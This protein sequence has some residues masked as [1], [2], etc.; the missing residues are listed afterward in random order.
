MP[1]LSLALVVLVAAPT[2]THAGPLTPPAGAPTPTNKTLSE[3]EPRIPLTQDT[4]PGTGF[5]VFNIL[6][7]GSYY[8][9][10]DLQAANLSGFGIVIGVSDVTIDLNGY[11]MRG[12]DTPS[13]GIFLNGPSISNVHLRNGT[14]SGFNNGLNFGPS[15]SAGSITDLTIQ[16]C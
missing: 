1:R 13:D 2:A 10:E 12:G 3:V 15:S 6:Q 4:A 9:V 16:D 14:I 8:L 11:T 7:P 5:V